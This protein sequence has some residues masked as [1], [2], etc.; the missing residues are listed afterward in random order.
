MN[1]HYQFWVD[2]YDLFEDKSVMSMPEGN[3][4]DEKIKK[5]V[6][7]K[8]TRKTPQQPLKNLKSMKI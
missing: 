8:K 5:T 1:L 3:K 7:R 2:Y 4:K 6:Q